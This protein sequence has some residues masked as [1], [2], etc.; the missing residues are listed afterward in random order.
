MLA[1]AEHT[2]SRSAGK[3]RYAIAGA[4]LTATRGHGRGPVGPAAIGFSGNVPVECSR[5]IECHALRQAV[6]DVPTADVVVAISNW[7]HECVIGEDHPGIDPDRYR[8]VAVRLKNF[9]ARAWL[10]TPPTDNANH[11]HDHDHP[12]VGRGRQL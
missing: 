12:H 7:L 4:K 5:L 9:R 8:P 11:R 10:W 2:G 1:A 6:R 3:T